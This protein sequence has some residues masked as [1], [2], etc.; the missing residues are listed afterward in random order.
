MNDIED[1]TIQSFIKRNYSVSTPEIKKEVYPKLGH[2]YQKLRLHL[3]HLDK[4]NL[5]QKS[6]NKNEFMEDC[7]A[8]IH[9]LAWP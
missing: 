2:S 1:K 6:Q 9:D 7:M 4:I 5:Y 8:K 3:K